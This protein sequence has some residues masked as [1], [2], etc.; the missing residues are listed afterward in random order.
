MKETELLEDLGIDERIIL[1]DPF[2]IVINL[3]SKGGYFLSSR[4]IGS[5]S[6]MHDT[7]PRNWF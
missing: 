5:F 2:T 3:R 7:D 6:R 4:A 1:L